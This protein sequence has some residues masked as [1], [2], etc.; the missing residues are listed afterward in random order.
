[1]V[2]VRQTSLGFIK[3]NAVL[4][5]PRMLFLPEKAFFVELPHCIRTRPRKQCHRAW[6]RPRCENDNVQILI[7][8]FSGDD[9]DTRQDDCDL[10]CPSFLF[11]D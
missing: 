10:C 6:W 2:K 7:W 8:E 11:M 1:M 4:L 9:C 3:S 5:F